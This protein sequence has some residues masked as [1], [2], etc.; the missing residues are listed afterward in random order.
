MLGPVCH[1]RRSLERHLRRVLVVVAVV[2]LNA[3][4]AREVALQRGQHRHPQLIAALPDRVKELAEVPAIRGTVL[5]EKAVL[6]EGAQGLPL[7]VRPALPGAVDAVE[8]TGDLAR[9]NELGI[10][11]SV[12]QEHFVPFKWYADVEHRGLHARSLVFGVVWRR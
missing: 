4:A 10:G 11:E 3:V 7:L 6:R 5:Y 9:D 12:H 1:P 2:T 8:Q